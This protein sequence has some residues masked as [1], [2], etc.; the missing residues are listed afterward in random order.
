LNASDPIAT[1]SSSGFAGEIN[2]Q[3]RNDWSSSA[4]ALWTTDGKTSQLGLQIHYLPKSN[5]RLF[6][7]GYSFRRDVAALNQKALRQTSTSFLQPLTENWRMLGL[8]QY[9]LLNKETP[10]ALLGLTYDACCWQI[11]LYRRQFLVDADNATASN[12]RR[13]A[14]FIEVTLK[15]LAGLSSGVNDLL[16][17]KVFGYSQTRENS[18]ALGLTP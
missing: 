5:D 4:D 14:F 6:N 1:A 2:A 15:G 3:L 11:S 8:W 7:V 9:D 12:R 18:A 10:D 17:N 13:S 16:K